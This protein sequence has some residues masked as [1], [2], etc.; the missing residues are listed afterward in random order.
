L[1]GLTLIESSRGPPQSKFPAL[2]DYHT[3]ATD[4]ECLPRRVLPNA[5]FA[6]MMRR[7]M[8]ARSTIGLMIVAAA[9]QIGVAGCY[10]PAKIQPP[11]PAKTQTVVEVPY[12]LTWDALQRVIND[13]RYKI[14]GNDP[15]DG[16]I[17]VES[18]AFTLGDADCGQLKSIANRYNA[19]PDPGGSA[20]Y[21][22][23]VEPAGREATSLSVNATFSTP[24]HVPLH[25]VTDFQ[26]VSRGIQEAR[27]LKEIEAAA[28]AERRPTPYANQPRDLTSGRNTL[29]RPDQDALPPTHVAPGGP[30]L[31]GNDFL[32]KPGVPSE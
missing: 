32:R 27:L 26:C 19:E 6:M 14:L 10:Y 2:G 1:N 31:M 30:S 17:E 12:D 18:Y 29:M 23:K 7:S 11:A 21:N 16:I 20:V 24:V 5:T 13:N 28:H 8:T 9:I 15:N 4:G 22:F 25:P 3:E